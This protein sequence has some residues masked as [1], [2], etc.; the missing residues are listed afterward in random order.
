[1]GAP[2][3]LTDG[4]VRRPTLSALCSGDG[5][6]RAAGGDNVTSRGGRKSW[7]R[8]CQGV[9]CRGRPSGWWVGRWRPASPAA[10]SRAVLV[11]GRVRGRI[12]QPLRRAARASGEWDG[13]TPPRRH[14]GGPAHEARATAA[15]ALVARAST[16][17]PCSPPRTLSQRG[18]SPPD[19]AR[20]RHTPSGSGRTR[21]QAWCPWPPCPCI[22]QGGRQGPPPAG[23]SSTFR[24]GAGG[25]VLGGSEQ[26]GSRRTWRCQCSARIF[27]RAARPYN[28]WMAPLDRSVFIA[29]SRRL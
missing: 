23:A 26:L 20:P 2:A 5:S 14:G 1:M 29:P 21:T 17:E 10:A 13:Q 24:R 16:D 3:R 25:R 9:R 12:F 7:V 19:P 8:V 28:P 4:Q 27:G 6:G 11:A 15:R 18:Q 22:P